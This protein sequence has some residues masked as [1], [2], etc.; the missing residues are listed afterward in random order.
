MKKTCLACLLT[1]GVL[2]TGCEWDSSSSDNSWKSLGDVNVA[3]VYRGPDGGIV[4]LGFAAEPSGTRNVSGEV[5]ATGDGVSTVYGGTFA[6]S[7]VVAG[8]VTITTAGYTF[9]DNGDGTLNGTG[10]ATGTMSYQTGSWTLNFDFDVVDN[11]ETIV[12]SYQYVPSATGGGAGNVGASPIYSFVVDQIG[13]KVTF[14]DSNGDGYQGR[15]SD[16]RTDS[17]TGTPVFDDVVTDVAQVVGVSYPFDVRGTSGGVGVK[18]VGSIKLSVVITYSRLD[19]GSLQEVY[20]R[21]GL[22][23][24]GTWIDDN[25]NTAAIE[26]VGPSDLEDIVI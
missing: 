25:G 18:M 21:R 22:V 12:A 10:T 5:I 6:N 14:T 19:D 20:Q 15:L 1:A 16:P 17:D 11:G 2:I 9:T 26:A 23:M 8:S 3:G 4:V 24:Q 13:N 7:A